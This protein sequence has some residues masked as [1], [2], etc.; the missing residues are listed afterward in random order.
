MPGASRSSGSALRAQRRSC[1]SPLPAHR[2]SAL[3]FK[4]SHIIAVVGA[5]SATLPAMWLERRLS[6][7]SS[8]YQDQGV[9]Q[10]PRQLPEL[11]PFLQTFGKLWRH[12]LRPP[13]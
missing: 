11:D 1:S 9:E 3:V 13:V 12:G 5:H 2:C 8:N 6:Q 7:Q 10:S 4:A